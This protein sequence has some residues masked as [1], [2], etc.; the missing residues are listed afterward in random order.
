MLFSDILAIIY[1]VLIY[2]YIHYL[3]MLVNKQRKQAFSQVVHETQ[4]THTKLSRFL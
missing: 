4:K 1:F 2:S 3:L